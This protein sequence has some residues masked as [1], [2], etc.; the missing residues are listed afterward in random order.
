M[1]NPQKSQPDNLPSQYRCERCWTSKNITLYPKS[2]FLKE[3]AAGFIILCDKCNSESPMEVSREIFENLYLR[4]ASPKELIKFYNASNEEEANEIWCKEHQ[5]EKLSYK[6]GKE[7]VA[8][9]LEEIEEEEAK[10][11]IPFGYFN[12]DGK[13]AVNPIEAEVVKD[14]FQ[15]YL[16][17]HTMEKIA[18]SIDS[19]SQLGT[20]KVRDILKN[21]LYAGYIYKGQE[22]VKGPQEAIIGFKS[23]NSV[24]RKIVRNIRNPKYLYKP[25][26]LQ[27]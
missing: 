17:G 3:D 8:L 16:D 24:Q 18:R 4:F 9:D 19:D 27:G 14:I 25:L 20:Q 1:A 26:E 23:Y 5:I 15:K 11:D 10:L 6:I 12:D 2:Q 21:P 13:L 22:V 7:E